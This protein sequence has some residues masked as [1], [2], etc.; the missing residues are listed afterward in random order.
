MFWPIDC[1][2]TT[3]NN[4]TIKSINEIRS[5]YKIS[6]SA[7]V[8]ILENEEQIYKKKVGTAIYELS[9]PSS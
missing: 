8:T 4:I 7:T 9:S 3:I 5:V 2:N 1:Y 6:F